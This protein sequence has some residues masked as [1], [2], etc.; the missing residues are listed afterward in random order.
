MVT[1]ALTESRVVDAPLARDAT[2]EYSIRQAAVADGGRPAITE[3]EPVATT[4]EFTLVRAI[5]RTGRTHPIRVHAAFIGH[6]I[7]GD[8]LYGP[9]PRFMLEFVRHGFT[10][11]MERTLIIDRQALH[12]A[13][14]TFYFGRDEITYTAPL[15]P[16]LARFWAEQLP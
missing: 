13:E 7:V 16:D 6:P 15:A 5:R 11:E 10:A 2:A 4:P 14:L 9:D 8:K 1:G 12:A 3:F